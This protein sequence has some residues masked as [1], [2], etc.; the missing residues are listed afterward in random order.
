MKLD[1]VIHRGDVVHEQVVHGLV[2]VAGVDDVCVGGED[3]QNCARVVPARWKSI[4][5][6]IGLSGLGG[7][8]EDDGCR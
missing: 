4:I 8:L 6:L 7:L 3:R 5:M 1:V 2:D